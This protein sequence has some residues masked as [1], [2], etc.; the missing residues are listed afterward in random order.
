M[1]PSNEK[2]PEKTLEIIA[3]IRKKAQSE[4]FGVPQCTR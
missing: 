2:T 4:V 3:Q 1:I